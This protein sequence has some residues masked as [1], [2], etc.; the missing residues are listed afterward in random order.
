M[1]EPPSHATEGMAQSV[2]CSV[3][4]KCKKST[5]TIVWNYSDM[6]SSIS[7]K[8]VSTDTFVARSNLTF[9]GSLDDDGKTLTCTAQFITGETSD[10]GTIHVKSEYAFYS[11]GTRGRTV[12]HFLR[13]NISTKVVDDFKSFIF[14][15]MKNDPR[16]RNGMKVGFLLNSCC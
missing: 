10:S 9:I 5:P 15:N 4:Y 6:Q 2:I 16:K 12:V 1:T 14:Q 3:S 13:E 7:I 8:K 11:V